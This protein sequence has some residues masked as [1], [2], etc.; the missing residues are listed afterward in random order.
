MK[1][2]TAIHTALST[3]FLIFILAINL[4]GCATMGQQKSRDKAGFLRL[5]KN[6]PVFFRRQ[7]LPVAL[8]EYLSYYKLSVNQNRYWFG[9][10]DVGDYHCAAHLSLPE[11]EPKGTVL[12]I[13]GFLSHFG[14]YQDLIPIL[15]E[16]EWAVA[17]IDLPGHGISSGKPTHIDDFSDYGAAVSALSLAIAGEAPRPFVGLG[18]S[19]GCAALLEYS[20][21]GGTMITEYIF[22]A[23]L[24]RSTMH[25]LTQF[26]FSLFN[27]VIKTLP[28]LYQKT[29]SDQE[30]LDFQ[31]NRDPLQYDAIQPSWVRALFSWNSRIEETELPSM[32]L[33][34]IQGDQDRV[35]DFNYNLNFYSKQLDNVQIF[36]IPGGRHELLK[37]AE[38]FKGT[39]FKY[40]LSTLNGTKP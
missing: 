32:K 21:N 20:L 10:I 22:V 40:I 15:L 2:S 6:R 36:T 17:G 7:E 28:R 14:F 13:H 24:V 34:I 11:G 25:G 27:P 18:H 4:G 29:S 23:P 9:Y 33:T 5:Q 31:E 3:L 39:T 1:K 35:V 38:P 26:G 16:N 12:L 8:S 19:M 37:E 30:Y